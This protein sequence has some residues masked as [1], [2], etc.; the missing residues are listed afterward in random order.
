MRE[1][2]LIKEDLKVDGRLY[3]DKDNYLER[4]KENVGRKDRDRGSK[5]RWFSGG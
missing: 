4:K 5:P 1:C 2:S 3:C